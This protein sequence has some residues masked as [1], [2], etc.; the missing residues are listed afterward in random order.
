MDVFIVSSSEIAIKGRPVRAQ[1][2]RTLAGNI[3]R[4]CGKDAAVTGE[5]GKLVVVPKD[6]KQAECLA[7]RLGKVFG[8]ANFSRANAFEFKDIDDIAKKVRE[9]FGASVSGKRFRV[10]ASREGKH[11]FTSMDI[12]RVVGAALCD[13]GG[14][15][16]LK[17]YEVEVFVEVRG[18]HAYAYTKKEGGPGGLPLGSEGKVV[19]LFSGG[20]DSPVAAWAMMRRGCTPAFLFVNLGGEETLGL[21]YGTYRKLSCEWAF[22]GDLG[23]YC[24]DGKKIVDA[25]REKVRPQLRQVVLKRTF[26]ALAARLC[27]KLGC[28][29]IVTG[30]SVGQVS[31][32]TIRNLAAIENGVGCLVLRP[33][34]AYT[35]EDTIREAKRIGTYEHSILMGELCNIS[36]GSVATSAD[37]REVDAEYEKIRGDVEG[38][39]VSI[40]TNAAESAKTTGNSNNDVII[41][42]DDGPIDYGSLDKAKRYVVVCRNG[43]LAARECDTLRKL[44]FKCTS[45]KLK[46]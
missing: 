36:E 42:L 12:Q 44:G 45:R 20:I 32:Q 38:T 15:V 7:G 1:M 14:K 22:G 43:V 8:I 23:F 2:V 25:I 5:F 24:A 21:A 10:T 6:K 35:K 27:R 16:S 39:D 30:E 19:V 18:K 37:V 28:D 33:L 29:A 31:T 40:V 34:I 9:R 46:K 26:Y 13:A 41:R 17:E 11:G 4:A 3:R